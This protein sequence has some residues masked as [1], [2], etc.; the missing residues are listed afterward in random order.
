MKYLKQII[1]YLSNTRWIIFIIF[2]LFYSLYIKNQV[3]D[4]AI[5]YN[6]NY[7]VWDIFFTF[8]SDPFFI[9][10][11]I[12]PIWIVISIKLINDSWNENIFIRLSSYRRWLRYGLTQTFLYAIILQGLIIVI[13]LGMSF[14][15]PFSIEWS[16]YSSLDILSNISY[17]L[18]ETN[19]PVLYAIAQIIYLLFFLLNVY[20]ILAVLFLF[21]PKYKV[22]YSLGV[23]IFIGIIISFK[24]FTNIPYL[25]IANYISVSYAYTWLFSYIYPI[26]TYIILMI[27]LLLVGKLKK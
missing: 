26:V 13:I 8:L 19:T 5:E 7:N 12:L 3:V 27:I 11:F 22:V 21:I 1:D 20:L 9:I 2:V 16:K 25:N 15:V 17:K 23:F 6:A 4:S 24:V 14:E 18:S 10:Y